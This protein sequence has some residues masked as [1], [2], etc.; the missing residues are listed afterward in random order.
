MNRNLKNGLVTV[1]IL[2]IFL[3]CYELGN[4]FRELNTRFGAN[5]DLIFL[6]AKTP[7][8]TIPFAA[9]KLLN[10]SK[11]LG[12]LFLLGSLVSPCFEALRN[13][14]PSLRLGGEFISKL[15][16]CMGLGFVL[17]FC[18]WHLLNASFLAYYFRSGGELGLCTW[19]YDLLKDL[20]EGN[21][22][23][24]YIGT[25]LLLWVVVSS[26]SI[27]FKAL[28]GKRERTGFAQHAL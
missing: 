4:G 28:K 15:P 1:V 11:F 8:F 22:M 7:Y 16:M 2:S 20:T 12:L 14:F 3:F 25:Q 6:I 13:R 9:E 21:L 27:S 19:W 24:I 10:H 5:V 26:F 18:I 17:T 23:P